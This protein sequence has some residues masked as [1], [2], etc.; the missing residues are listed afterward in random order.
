MKIALIASAILI[1]LVSC[2]GK[3]SLKKFEVNGT[4]TNNT[5]RMIYLEEIPVA[6]MQSARVDS[7]LLQKDGKF[8][9]KTYAREATVYNLRLDRGAY[10]LAAI[11]NDNSK[12]TVNATL[13]KENSLFSES[14]EVTGSAASTKMKDFMYSFN[15]KLQ[16]IF[17]NSREADS[18]QKNDASDSLL[19]SLKNERTKIAAELR[20]LTLQSI[21]ASD[22]PALS[23]FELGYYQSTANNPAFQL[24]PINNIEVNEIVNNIAE[25]FPSHSGVQLV[26]TS[27]N[28]ESQKQQGMVGKQA[29]EISLTDMNG[30]GIKLSSYRGSYVLIDFWASWCAPCRRESPNL[31]STYNNY[32]DKNFTILSVSVDE[33][34]D[35]WRKAVQQDG[36][37]W[38]QVNEPRYFNSND[39]PEYIFD[40]I[41][42]NV[43]VDPNGTIIAENLRGSYLGTKLEE[44]LK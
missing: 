38:T 25:K 43:L 35:E 30:K 28:A 19:S 23:M 36:L 31:V 12:I 42:F 21:E 14:Y 39:V 24:E 6:T 27:L 37:V 29:P 15:N 10:P 11:I 26:K 33:D 22:N 4:L 3:S 17:Y 9:L 1:S 44:V 34:K 2:T 8:V 18:L 16:A 40:A 41:P 20:N 7:A 13:S 32:K 5:A